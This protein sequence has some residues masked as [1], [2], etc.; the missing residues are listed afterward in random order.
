[1]NI[2]VDTHILLWMLNEPERLPAAQKA[3][4]E[5][6]D[7]TLI[8]SAVTLCE[9]SIKYGLG[10]LKLPATPDLFFPPHLD[11]PGMQVLPVLAAHAL[12]LYEL[13]LHHRDPFDRILIAQAIV[14][15]LPI[16]TADAQFRR[17]PI[18]VL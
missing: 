8:I 10:K 16:M 7:H 11:Q 4:L 9:I 2:L 3:L 17:Y 12:R 15:K 6:S 5:D 14:E 13:P 1:V 18:K